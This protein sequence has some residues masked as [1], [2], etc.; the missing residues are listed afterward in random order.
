MPKV[1]WVT[2]ASGLIGSHLLGVP[3][4]SHW[5]VRALTHQQLDLCNSTAL[6]AAF[7]SDKPELIFHCAALTRSQECEQNPALAWRINF[8]ATQQLCD[9]AANARLIFFSTD[10]VFDGCV[11]HYDERAEV[12]PQMVYAET[13]AA[14]ERIVLAHPNHTVVRTSLNAGPS[15]T[16]DR[17]FD[18]LL[19][20]AW[21]RGETPRLFM[22]EFRTPI[23]AEVTARAVWE[24]AEQGLAGLYHVAGAQRLSRFEIGQLLAAR[25]PELHPKIEACSL[26]QFTGAPRPP[27]T[28][29]DC[30]KVQQTLSFRLPGFAEWLEQKPRK[31]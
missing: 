14:A 4:A 13:K 20:G 27:D 6:Q 11:G 24:M 2:G 26:K 8:Y 1:A 5:Q 12:N 29:L 21:A 15:P 16:G 23:G 22:D 10:L 9:L 3:R 18:E 30:R 19:R 17:A 31:D 25:W 28:S 7:N